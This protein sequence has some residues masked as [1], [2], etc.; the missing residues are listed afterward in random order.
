MKKIKGFENYN[1]SEDGTII[2]TITG[3]A[4][5]PTD[6]HAGNGYLYVD[7]YN[8]GERKR[9]FIH[10]LVAEYYV[11]NPYHKPVVNHIDGNTKNNNA[12]NLEWCT[13][14]ENV[15]HAANI[16]HVMKPYIFA[17]EKRKRPIEGT[18]LKTKEVKRYK[19]IREAERELCIPSSNIVANLK[20]RQT[21]TRNIVWRYL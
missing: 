1:I 10:R 4:K 18:N 20:G 16:L 21:H 8:N 13:S 12:N 15:S 5:V 9:A 11:D 3:K 14:K 6:N 7:L 19:S 2:N 17:N